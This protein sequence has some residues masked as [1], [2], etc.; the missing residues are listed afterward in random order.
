MTRRRSYG[1]LRTARQSGGSRMTPDR[2]PLQI[3]G[4]LRSAQLSAQVQ[5]KLN[6]KGVGDV[7]KKCADEGE[8]NEGGWRGAM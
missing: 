5:E 2:S 4:I 1:R 3:P 8:D 6:D 7:D